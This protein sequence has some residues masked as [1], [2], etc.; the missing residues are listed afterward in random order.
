MGEGW[1]SGGES[2]IW[3]A[4]LGLRRDHQEV[5][6]KTS[7]SSQLPGV[8]KAFRTRSGRETRFTCKKRQ[9]FRC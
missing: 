7:K 8:G 2:K 1:E 5:N 3:G 6:W 9:N 4:E